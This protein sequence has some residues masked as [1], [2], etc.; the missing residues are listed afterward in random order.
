MIQESFVLPEWEKIPLV[1]PYDD[2]EQ[3]EDFDGKI[4]EGEEQ[5]QLPTFQNR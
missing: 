3:I 1:I 4:D 2:E 5:L